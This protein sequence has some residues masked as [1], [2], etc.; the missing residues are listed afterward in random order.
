MGS[1]NSHQ[2]TRLMEGEVYVCHCRDLQRL[3]SHAAGRRA[4]GPL[5]EAVIGLRPGFVVGH[6]ADAGGGA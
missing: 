2:L 6:D 3:H 4:H 1:T 5:H